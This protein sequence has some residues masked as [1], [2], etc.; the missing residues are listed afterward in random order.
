M[1]ANSA[2]KNYKLSLKV[3]AQAELERRRRAPPTEDTPP[4]DWHNWLLYLF[5]SYIS[6]PFADRHVE[7]WAWGWSI[8]TGIRPRPFVAVWPRGGAKSTSAELLT[9]ALGARE[10][11]KYAW[12]ISGVQ[13]QADKHVETIGSALESATVE[14]YYPD[15]ARRKV[16]KYGNSRGWRRNRLRSASG[17]TIDALGLDTASRGAK[18]EEQRPDLMILDDIDD[19]LDR[20]A[21]TAK[22]IA[23]I[24]STLLPSGAPG[25]AV[26]AI[27]NLLLPNGV[28]AQLVA[29]AEFL[30]DRILS[31]PYPAIDGFGYETRDGIATITGG[32][33]TWAGQSLA[34]CQQQITTWGITAFEHEAQHEVDAPAGGMFDHLE[35]RHCAW[36][37]VPDLVRTSVWVDPAI[38]STDDSDAMGIQADGIDAEDT[39][40]RIYSWEA[41]TTPQDCLRR[42]I[43]KAVEL[44]ADTLGVETDQGGDTWQSVFS[45]AW[46]R[47][48]EE[49]LVKEASKPLFKQAKA[50]A[51]HGPKAHRASQMLAEYEHGRFVHVLG[52]HTALEK[53]LRRF[54]KAKPFDL[55][56]AAYWS[57]NDIRN[58]PP[59]ATTSR[60]VTRTAISEL[61][62]GSS[63]GF[64]PE[65]R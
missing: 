16:G 30:A 40:Y 63:E 3:K 35:Y 24:T 57:W 17:F 4:T 5:P 44:G 41:V 2:T 27:Q 46:R 29:G 53:A 19:K 9:V 12:Y 56:D 20:P 15:L 22:K 8:Q 37:A 1:C 31:G 48:S 59:A 26:L 33:A 14:R 18:I 62:G 7:L 52:T 23:T 50:G 38:T 43:M 54:P 58:A 51:G 47:L 6:A 39:I 64:N 49:G 21:A 25:L 65:W 34:I 60:V 11:R 55:V 28:F 45:E 42:A 32:T 10:Q 61:L 13:D 36:D